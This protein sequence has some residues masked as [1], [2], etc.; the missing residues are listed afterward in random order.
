MKKRQIVGALFSL[1]LGTVIAQEQ[2]PQAV[3]QQDE[4]VT[5]HLGAN[6]SKDDVL[7]ILRS[8]DKFETN[9]YQTKVFELQ[10]V[11]AY[12]MLRNIRLAVDLEKGLVRGARAF[13]DDGSKRQFLIVTTTPDHMVS[14]AEAIK[15]LDVYGLK[16]SQGST[17]VAMRVK[18]RR[19]SELAEVLSSTRFSSFTR[20]YADDITNT[21]FYADTEYVVDAV[22]KYV[23]FYDVPTPQIEFDVRIFEV[24]EE[25][26]KK[27]GLDWDAWKRSVGGQFGVTGNVFENGDSFSRFDG[28]LTLD[29]AALADFLNYTVQNGSGRLVQR[30]RLNA[31]NLR[32]AV[33]TDTRRIPYYDYLRSTQSSKILYED[34]ERVSTFGENDYR[35]R[36]TDRVV[37]IT[38]SV[39]NVKYSLS[40]EEE[41]M[42][43]E[44]SPV[45][46]ALSVRA[47]ILIKV[48]TL[49]GYDQLDRPLV[50]EQVLS[51]QFTLQDGEQI[52]LGTLE[53]QTEVTEERGIPF[54]KDIPV[55]K[56]LFN[57]E[58]SRM[59]DSRVFIV[60][61][62]KF[63]NVRFNA[64][65]F[66]ELLT[67]DVLSITER[68][69]DYQLDS[70]L[71]MEIESD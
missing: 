35:D 52:L 33:L 50:T 66:D 51:N 68:P 4:V 31:S 1:L 32:P 45:I 69:I 34:N 5:I 57:V 40:Y 15:T 7:E 20:V 42:I 49:T 43:I 30:S 65:N 67:Q 3:N 18:Y 16:N 48:N 17:Q 47:D 37:E 56:V 13:Q 64:Q 70:D 11:P 39:Q 10:N 46:S 60:A 28:L 14:I 44:I 36:F 62:P 61:T 55:L 58:T 19:A 38:P 8:D 2:P 9:K 24:R 54:L 26:N 53:R 22:E 41:G 27:L 21:L 23:R 25:D 29:A 6:Q 12:E 59:M 71:L 63:S